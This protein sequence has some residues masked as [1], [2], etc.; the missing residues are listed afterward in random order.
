MR[1]AEATFGLLAVPEEIGGR[2][3]GQLYSLWSTTPSEAEE[4]GI[5]SL[6]APGLSRRLRAHLLISFVLAENRL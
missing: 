3:D 4:S 6:L 1:L 5:A 2:D